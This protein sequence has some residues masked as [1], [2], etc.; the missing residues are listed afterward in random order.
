MSSHN[1]RVPLVLALNNKDI[2]NKQISFLDDI[3][4]VYLSEGQAIYIL[5]KNNI[6]DRSCSSYL[7]G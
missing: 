5:N 6:L 4:R 3:A 2:Q 1:K 7:M